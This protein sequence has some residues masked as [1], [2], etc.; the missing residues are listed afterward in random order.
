MEKIKIK[1]KNFI[2]NYEQN[3]KKYRTE[4]YKNIVNNNKSYNQLNF[5]ITFFLIPIIIS[6]FIVVTGSFNINSYIFAFFILIILNFIINLINKKD[7]NRYLSEIK[8]QGCFSI[9]EYEKK[10]KKY[11]TGPGGYYDTLLNY[12]KK[13]YNINDNTRK[14]YGINGEEY[15]IWPN[16]NQD[17]INILNNKGV[18]KPELKS[19]K[20]INVRYFRVDNEQRMIVLK[21]DTED[22][23]LTLNSF[24]TLNE[25]FKQKRLENLIAFTPEDYINDFEIYMHNLKKDI[26]TDPNHTGEKLQDSIIKFIT[27]IVIT[28]IVIGLSYLIKDYQ[29]IIRAISLIGIIF[30]NIY[31]RNIFSYETQKVKTDEEYIEYLNTNQECLNKFEELKCSLGIS[32]AFNH[33]YT[34]EGACYLTWVANGYFHVFLNIVY[35]NVVYMAINMRDVLY[36]KEEKNECIVK[37]KD[38]TLSFRKDAAKTFAKILPNKDYEWLKGYQNNK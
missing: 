15:F 26:S 21:T 6:S 1:H 11:V 7:S 29:S 3:I 24:N 4:Y 36:Y 23:H 37:T 28:A 17:A 34:N 10:L 35:F 9:E 8:K 25:I 2:D 18:A 38:R 22:F 5:E 32:N 30:L 13:E 16:Q 14:I 20:M 19:I 27:T 12:Y 31:L 33:V